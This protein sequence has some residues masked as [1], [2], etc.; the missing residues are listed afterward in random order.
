MDQR[1]KTSQ[2]LPT[3]ADH[4]FA[5]NQKFGEP[6]LAPPSIRT[7]LALS[8]KPQFHTTLARILFQGILK[9][10]WEIDR[11]EGADPAIWNRLSN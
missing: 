10:R 1:I 11:L 5:K 7:G 8:I 6:L 2:E 3:K 4:R 9:S